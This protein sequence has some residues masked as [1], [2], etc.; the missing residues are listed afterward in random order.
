MG[1]LRVK[2]LFRC[3]RWV[4]H[5]IVVAWIKYW[6]I[7]I[8]N[9]IVR[10]IIG[11]CQT[12]IPYALL[13]FVPPTLDNWVGIVVTCHLPTKVPYTHTITLAAA[14]LSTPKYACLLIRRV[15]RRSKYN[16]TLIRWPCGKRRS[17]N[18]VQWGLWRCEEVE[19]G[20][21]FIWEAGSTAQSS[22]SQYAAKQFSWLDIKYTYSVS[23][24]S[25]SPIH[26]QPWF[27]QR[28]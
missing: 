25:Q 23:S 11:Y 20:E 27:H 1:Y 13:C 8:G 14:L 17:E 16:E 18:E 5:R 26:R 6:W 24:S 21:R 10:I 7:R 2:W 19:D 9:N 3:V 28:V 12:V 22:S 15:M 4:D